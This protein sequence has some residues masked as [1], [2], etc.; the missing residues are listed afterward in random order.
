MLSVYFKSHLLNK[1]CNC[2]LNHG[3]FNNKSMQRQS[4][5]KRTAINYEFSIIIDDLETK[6]SLTK[7]T[8]YVL[9]FTSIIGVVFVVVISG[10]DNVKLNL[11]LLLGGGFFFFHIKCLMMNGRA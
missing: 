7:I 11:H 2:C 3:L 9:T 4:F 6:Q 5:R 8:M 1:S 10:Y